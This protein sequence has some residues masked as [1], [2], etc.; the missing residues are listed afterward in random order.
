MGYVHINPRGVFHIV[1]S[2]LSSS[3][4]TSFSERQRQLRDVFILTAFKALGVRASE[5]V[6]AKMGAFYQFTDPATG[7]RY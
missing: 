4:A 5:P 7:N 3:D 1:L 2:T 6:G